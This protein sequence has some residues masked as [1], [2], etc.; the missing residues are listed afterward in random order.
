MNQTVLLGEVYPLTAA[1]REIWLDQAVHGDAPVYK[2]GG[3][4]RIA[5]SVDAACFERA[6]NLLVARHD[7]LRLVLVPGENGEGLPRQAVAKTLTVEVPLHDFSAEPDPHAA[8]IAWA[9]QRLAESFPLDGRPLFRFELARID[10]AN[11]LFTLN[12]HHLIVDGWAIGLLVDSLARIYSALAQG[13]EPELDAPSYLEFVEQDR[14]FR[15]SP[16]FERQRAYCSTSTVRCPTRCSRRVLASA[17]TGRSRRAG[18]MRCACRARSTIASPP[19]RGAAS[20]RR[21]M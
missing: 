21:S 9:R 4:T 16:Q 12:F 1:Q 3:Y 6:V 10:A 20:R 7:A 19:S 18:T 5:G 14:A 8:A 13:R 11:F 15:E 17:S 2:I